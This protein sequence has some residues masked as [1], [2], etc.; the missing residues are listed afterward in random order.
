MRNKR[1]WTALAAALLAAGMTGCA[2][3][4]ET[5]AVPEEFRL[6]GQCAAT[7]EGVYRVKNT[8]E[9]YETGMDGY[10][11]CY[12]DWDSCR[13]TLLC[14]REGCTHDSED[15]PAWVGQGRLF[16]T[17]ADGSL[18]VAQPME[19]GGN[20]V[21]QV[22]PDGSE[23]TLA[24]QC[25]AAGEDGSLLVGKN[26]AG[27]WAVAFRE[28][29]AFSLTVW[30]QPGQWTE[31]FS[32][33]E[34]FQWPQMVRDN[35]FYYETWD[36]EAKR[37]T[38]WRAALE[39]SARPEAVVEY[40][41]AWTRILLQG[42]RVWTADAR[43]GE[44]S[45]QPLDGTGEPE[46]VC[47]LPEEAREHIIEPIDTDGSRMVLSWGG[48]FWAVDLATGEA[49]RITPAGVDAAGND[50]LPY[51]STGSAGGAWALT[52]G[53]LRSQEG[54]Q[55]TGTSIRRTTLYQPQLC[56]LDRDALLSG[57]LSLTEIRS[58]F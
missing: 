12:I 34:V 39:L 53:Y 27:I 7:A 9:S 14:T 29:G 20:A 8:A 28:G 23:K 32:S 31:V 35:V 52:D 56:R 19:N 46:A 54:I 10:R 25:P 38:L 57:N 26:E 16:G 5:P 3:A 17:E 24:A 58:D 40:E 22:A 37:A 51:Y 33:G 44:V 45:V 13:E 1:K 11:L 6:Q 43:T 49:T 42:D 21:W 15:C 47:T 36:N 41:S 30:Q 50:L 48:S 4:G 55:Y 2:A 18:L